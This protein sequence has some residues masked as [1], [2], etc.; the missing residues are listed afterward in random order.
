LASYYP[1]IIFIS[2]IHSLIF[3]QQINGVTDRNPAIKEKMFEK[4][5]QI[6]LII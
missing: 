1:W 2:F 6:A 5:F 3:C 4:P